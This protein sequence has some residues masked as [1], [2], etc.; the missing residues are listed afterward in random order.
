M[1]IIIATKYV[2]KPMAESN[3]ALTEDSNQADSLAR[4]PLPYNWGKFQGWVTLIA[5]P[6]VALARH[7]WLAVITVPLMIA[8]GYAF[9]R[10][11]KYAVEMTYAW[12][13]FVLVVSLFVVAGSPRVGR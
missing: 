11:R 13:A 1:S 12:M 9:V 4:T 2:S 6:F 7:G 3:P 5:G 10:R 8:S